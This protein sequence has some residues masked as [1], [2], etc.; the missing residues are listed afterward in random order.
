LSD[1]LYPLT[2][3]NLPPWLS[4]L[5]DRRSLA[6][7]AD[8]AYLLATDGFWSCAHPDAFIRHW[9]ALCADAPDAQALVGRLFAA[10]ED[11]PPSGL[12]PDNLTALVL[13]PLP[14]S[15]DETALPV[16]GAAGVTD[17]K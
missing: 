8:H 1:P 10:M 2:P 6:L 7:R 14:H 4:H 11:D 13:R 5:P 12:Q 16:E 17:G 3:L 9:P 15:A